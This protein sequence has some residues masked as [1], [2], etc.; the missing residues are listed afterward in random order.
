MADRSRCDFHSVEEEID[1]QFYVRFM[2]TRHI[3]RKLP[4]VT[5]TR[6]QGAFNQHK[7]VKRDAIMPWQFP[8]DV[9]GWHETKKK[10]ERLPVI[11]SGINTE[12]LLGVPILDEAT[13]IDQAEVV[14]EVFNERNITDRIKGMYFNIPPVNKNK[15][16]GLRF[17][18]NSEI[19]LLGTSKRFLRRRA[20]Q[21]SATAGAGECFYLLVETAKFKYLL[22]LGQPS[23]TRRHSSLA[24]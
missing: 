20:L 23:F 12:Q 10:V 13:G 15:L 11:V 24:W 17:D 19:K 2:R 16:R 4:T 14:F 22:I 7:L 6:V 3:L 8:E 21:L 9:P 1:C 18:I 5:S